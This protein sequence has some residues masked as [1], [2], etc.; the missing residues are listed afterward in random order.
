M[1]I[2]TILFNLL[3]CITLSTQAMLFDG[4]SRN[5]ELQ[6]DKQP[7]QR[8]TSC[9][10]SI[11]PRPDAYYAYEYR[12]Y[13][14]SRKIAEYSTEATLS[15][16]VNEHVNP[17]TDKNW[18]FKKALPLSIDSKYSQEQSLILSCAVCRVYNRVTKD[19]AENIIAHL[20][21]EH[22]V[23]AQYIN[24]IHVMGTHEHEQCAWLYKFQ[25]AGCA[26]W[27]ASVVPN[28][29]TFTCNCEWLDSLFD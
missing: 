6:I 20:D 10:R 27:K 1:N 9:P 17:I 22:E 12:E 5:S 23:S 18:V 16:M 25:C 28:T 8:H 3:M 19:T 21:E 14:T 7:K 11:A 15:S 13:S 26:V 4:T 24:Y 2:S 29:Q